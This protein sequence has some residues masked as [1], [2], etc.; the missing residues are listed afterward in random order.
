MVQQAKRIKVLMAQFPLE[1][2]SRGMITVAGMLKDAGMEVVLVG[3]D[4]PERIIE[5]I[6]RASCRERV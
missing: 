5:K 2:H 1:S 6:G 4:M 3:N